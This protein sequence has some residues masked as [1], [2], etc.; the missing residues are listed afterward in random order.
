MFKLSGMGNN[1]IQK[2]QAISETIDFDKAIHTIRG[3]R[4]ML[5]SDLAQLFGVP[6]KRVNEAVRRN[7]ERFPFPFMFVLTAQEVT[8]LR[9]QIATLKLG[10]G[11]HTKYPPKVFTEHGAIMLASL[12]NSPQ[13]IEASIYVVNAF[14]RMRE[15]LY[16]HK[17]LVDKLT[18]LE[19]KVL[20]HDSDIRAIVDAIRQLMT[21]PSPPR[22]R[23]GFNRE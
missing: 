23:I 11:K 19:N 2:R 6:T 3:Q 20:A 13:A 22:K 10:H 8:N 14:V 1:R 9:S 7:P 5:D 21:P 18:A 16:S 4:V 17:E 15:L 12:L